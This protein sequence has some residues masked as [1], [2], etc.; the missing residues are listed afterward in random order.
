M[1]DWATETVV[2]LVTLGVLLA[3][4]SARPPGGGVGSPGGPHRWMCRCWAE[5]FV[6]GCA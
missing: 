4:I 2:A 6:A 3:T 1:A 5:W